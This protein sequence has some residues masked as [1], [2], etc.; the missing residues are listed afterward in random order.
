MIPPGC[1]DL[2]KKSIVV[3][4]AGNRLPETKLASNTD[5]RKNFESLSKSYVPGGRRCGLIQLD[6]FW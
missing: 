5:P 3:T 4:T 6:C 1:K 2:K